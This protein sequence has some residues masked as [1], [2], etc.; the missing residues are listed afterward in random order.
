MYVLYKTFPSQNKQYTW[1]FPAPYTARLH[2]W[3]IRN[4]LNFLWFR[5]INTWMAYLLILWT[6]S[7]SSE[8]IPITSKISSHLNLK[9]LEQR[10]SAEIV[11]GASQTWKNVPKEIR[12][13]VSLL[14]FKESIKKVPLI[15]CLFHC[16]KTY[17]HY[18]GYI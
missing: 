14:I 2:K 11:Y 10:S 13:S 6:L 1:E 16:C 12:N 18:V 3:F 17:I 8:K 4:A 9:I 15:S 5:F 7:L